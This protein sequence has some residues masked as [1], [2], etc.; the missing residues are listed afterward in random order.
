[1][2]DCNISDT[3]GGREAVSQDEHCWLSNNQ[4]VGQLVAAHMPTHTHL[5]VLDPIA[6]GSKVPMRDRASNDNVHDGQEEGNGPEVA[7]EVVEAS[8]AQV[9]IELDVHVGDAEAVADCQL[10]VGDLGRAH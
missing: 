5:Q 9:V 4:V 1:M 7:K 2:G 8:V 10:G 6:R 3:K